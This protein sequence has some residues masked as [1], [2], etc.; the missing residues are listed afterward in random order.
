MPELSEIIA[1][2]R[3]EPEKIDNNFLR[4]VGCCKEIRHKISMTVGFFYTCQER[5]PMK[6][7]CPAISYSQHGLLYAWY[8][9]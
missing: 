1:L 7:M 9:A 2:Q 6:F 8:S 5:A 3:M 4:L